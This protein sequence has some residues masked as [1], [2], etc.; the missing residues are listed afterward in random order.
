MTYV[1]ISEDLRKMTIPSTEKVIGCVGDRNVRRV[2]FKMPRYCDD[3][4]LATCRIQVHYI[5]AEGTEDYYEVP[6]RIV[7]DTS[8]IFGWLVGRIACIAEGSVNANVKLRSYDGP[9]ISEEFN[10]GI[11]RF[12]VK[13]AFSSD[14]YGTKLADMDGNLIVPVVD[15]DIID[16]MVLAT[17]DSE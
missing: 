16:I 4:D 7:D 15:E 5:N 9:I 13:P 6:N 14:P 8:I 12:K 1:E 10:S 17:D 11:G 3:T 2:Y